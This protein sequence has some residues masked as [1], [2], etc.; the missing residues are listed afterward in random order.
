ML[1]EQAEMSMLKQTAVAEMLELEEEKYRELFVDTGTILI[2]S[3]PSPRMCSLPGTLLYPCPQ[4]N[5][6]FKK[7]IRVLVLFPWEQELFF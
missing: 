6:S 3:L 1:L 7:R 2:F 4:A 5:W